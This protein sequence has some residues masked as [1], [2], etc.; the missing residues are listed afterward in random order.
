M[1]NKR[2]VPKT[3]RLRTKL[4]KGLTWGAKR[5]AKCV[6]DR[7]N[8]IQIFMRVI[9]WLRKVLYVKMLAIFLKISDRREGGGLRLL[10]TIGYQWEQVQRGMKIVRGSKNEKYGIINIFYHSACALGCSFSF[11]WKM[12]CLA[13][14]SILGRKRRERSSDTRIGMRGLVFPQLANS[15]NFVHRLGIFWRLSKQTSSQKREE[16]RKEECDHLF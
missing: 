13:F 1:P 7:L 14:V 11:R 8:F 16:G 6:I 9:L 4:I 5:C 3:G 12:A 2:R 15:I 10:D